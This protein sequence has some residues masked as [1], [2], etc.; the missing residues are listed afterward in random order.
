MSSRITRMSTRPVIEEIQRRVEFFH[1]SLVWKATSIQS[2]KLLRT[3]AITLA[4]CN[5]LR[6][7]INQAHISSILMYLVAD[8][9]QNRHRANSALIHPGSRHKG[10]YSLILSRFFV[11]RITQ[12]LSYKTADRTGIEQIPPLSTPVL[13]ARS[14]T[15]SSFPGFSLWGLLMY[16]N[17]RL[18]TEQA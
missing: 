14:P 13:D 7:S 2:L 15:H 10:S 17:T 16:F 1:N 5:N 12:V 3:V 11:V 4:E 18:L 9:Y 6:N 8:C